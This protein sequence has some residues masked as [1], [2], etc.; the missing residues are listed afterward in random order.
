MGHP[1]VFCGSK[2]NGKIRSRNNGKIRSRNNGKIRS[3]NN[4]KI[5]S[6]SPRLAKKMA[7]LGHENHYDGTIITIITKTH[8]KKSWIGKT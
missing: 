6:N 5:R 2:D 1:R 4:G 7:N 3:R 8:H